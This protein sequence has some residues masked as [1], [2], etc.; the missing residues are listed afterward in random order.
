MN[1]KNLIRKNIGLRDEND[2]NIVF[3]S[4]FISGDEQDEILNEIIKRYNSY[5][6]LKSDNRMYKVW[7][8]VAGITII[9]LLLCV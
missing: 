6:K 1:P 9:S 2:R 3:A 4:S 7:L 5:D 8:A